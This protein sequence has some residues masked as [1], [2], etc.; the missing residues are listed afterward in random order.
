[1]VWFFKVFLLALDYTA[2]DVGKAWRSFHIS[3]AG[4]NHH[5]DSI[6]PP[7]GNDFYSVA[8]ASGVGG[9]KSAPTS[10]WIKPGR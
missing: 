7:L 5:S 3:F 1:M 4:S 2:N 10:I 9:T 6:L 8:V